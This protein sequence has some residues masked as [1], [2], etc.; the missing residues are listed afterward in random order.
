MDCSFPHV[1]NFS[2]LYKDNPFYKIAD[3]SLLVY[4]QDIGLQSSFGLKYNQIY[5]VGFSL[6]QNTVQ[7]HSGI[8]F[9]MD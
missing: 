2:Y 3:I 9:I 4:Q 1:W 7:M 6:H 8:R 5:L